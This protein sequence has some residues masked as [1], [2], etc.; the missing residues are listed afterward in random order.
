[1]HKGIFITGTDTEVGKTVV[2]A[3]LASALK[4]RGIDVGVMK[5][6]ASGAEKKGERVAIEVESLSG[7][8]DVV[9]AVSNVRK[10]LRLADRVECIVR[11]K[12]SARTLME[13]LKKSPIEKKEFRLVKIRVI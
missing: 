1:M 4:T 7:T 3:G 9:H 12:K 8:K 2:A 6:V 10:A 13:T 5:P 11:N